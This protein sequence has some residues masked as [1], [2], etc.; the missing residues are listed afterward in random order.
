MAQT[1]ICDVL[2]SNHGRV[3]GYTSEI[4]IGSSRQIAE[5]LPQFDHDQIPSNH[6]RFIIHC[7][8]IIRRYTVCDTDKVV[9]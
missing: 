7:C 8:P 3:I 2:G 4:S 1:C 9:K 6:F 5:I